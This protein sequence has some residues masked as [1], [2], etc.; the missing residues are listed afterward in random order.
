ML[1]FLPL[2]GTAVFPVQFFLGQNALR[3]T[4]APRSHVGLRG[5][6]IFETV[7][8]PSSVV[9][10]PLFK[11]RDESRWSL[12]NVTL[13]RSAGWGMSGWRSRPKRNFRLESLTYGS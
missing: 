8:G 3:N 9:S 5:Y 4:E 12:G 1:I 10:G 7:S 6:R 2:P 13:D 11:L